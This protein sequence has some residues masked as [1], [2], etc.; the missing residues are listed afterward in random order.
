MLNNEVYLKTMIDQ[1]KAVVDNSQ[2]RFVINDLLY[3]YPL[4][5]NITETDIRKALNWAVSKGIILIL[6]EAYSSSPEYIFSSINEYQDK[7]NEVK[8]TV[9]APKAASITVGKIIERNK[10]IPTDIAFREI[11]ASSNHI[12]RIS[13]PFFQQ[14]V[15]D[16]NSPL[17]LEKSILLAYNR[18]CKIVI[19]SRET[20]SKRVSDLNWLVN[21]S[22]SH[23][24]SDRLEIFDYHKAS[25]QR[26]IDSSVHAKLIIADEK[27]AYIGSAELRLNSLYKNFE[28]GV[29]LEGPA[30]IGVIELFDE[31]IAL[32]QKVF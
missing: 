22:R 25:K 31:M 19:L 17:D 14:N 29:V 2:Q 23:G 21:L 24:F 1:I 12:I 18:G 6:N 10:F 7:I 28:V 8:I 32:S 26:T 11:I 4:L 13:S 16:Q 5:S 3:N 15:S 30:V 27:M 20:K 9:T